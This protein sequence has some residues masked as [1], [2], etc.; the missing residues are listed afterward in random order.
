MKFAP[1]AALAAA[2]ALGLAACSGDESTT[3]AETTTTEATTTVATTTEENEQTTGEETVAGDPTAGRDVYTSTGCGTCHTL[4]AAGSTGTIGPNLDEQLVAS[5]QEAGK[6]LPDFT[7]ESIE[8]PDAYVPEG[9]QAGTMPSNYDEQLSGEQ[10]DDLVAFVVQ[11][12]G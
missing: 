8:D 12:V 6:D 1:I 3:A 7:R 5:A 9:Y 4:S 10:I 11:S 2:L